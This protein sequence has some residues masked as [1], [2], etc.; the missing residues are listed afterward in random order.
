MT[1]VQTCALPISLL[2]TF[3]YFHILNSAFGTG[4]LLSISKNS[5]KWSRLH[6]KGEYIKPQSSEKRSGNKAEIKLEQ[7]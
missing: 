6:F 1:G 4:S 2:L 3:C 7:N 5:Y